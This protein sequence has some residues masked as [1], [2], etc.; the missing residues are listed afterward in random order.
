MSCYGILFFMK[1][2]GWIFFSGL[3]WFGAGVS[4]LYKGLKFVSEGIL[5]QDSL[6]HRMQ[7]LFGSSQQAATALVAIGLLIGLLKGRFV[8][9]KTVN[10]VV[11]RIRSL[12]LPIRF[13]QVYAR[14]YWILIASM[15]GLG[16]SLRFLPIPVD[17]RGLV[18]V[19]IGSALI[20]GAMLYFRV[21]RVFNPTTTV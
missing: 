7:G 2:K 19:A 11:N 13:S 6:S 10:R 3:F 18:D 12:P 17:A 20:N 15:V 14:S 21:A 16:V 9:S 5:T 4:L 1:H 8:L